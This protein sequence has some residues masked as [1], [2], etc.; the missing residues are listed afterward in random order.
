MCVAMTRKAAQEG[1]AALAIES[2]SLARHNVA[3]KA[4]IGLAPPAQLQH[5]LFC[6]ISCALI[7][8]RV[9]YMSLHFNM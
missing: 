2:N 6:T 5:T 1:A 9:F 4:G 7:P 8:A 3:E